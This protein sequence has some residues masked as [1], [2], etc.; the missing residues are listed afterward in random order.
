MYIT[1]ILDESQHLFLEYRVR[2]ELTL[3]QGLRFAVSRVTDPPP[4][5]LTG[6]R[7]RF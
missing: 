2:I 7:E 6:T 5:H 3:L 1:K 4:T